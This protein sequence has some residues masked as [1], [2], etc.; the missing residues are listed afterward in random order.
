ML[1]YPANYIIASVIFTKNRNYEEWLYCKDTAAVGIS[2]DARLLELISTISYVIKLGAA[3][4]QST[5][6][7][8]T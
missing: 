6:S 1:K 2:E 5:L 8:Q 4:R 7:T 3:K